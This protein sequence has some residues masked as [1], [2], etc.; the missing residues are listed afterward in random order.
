MSNSEGGL[1]GDL[2]VITPHRA[3]LE[4]SLI[5]DFD[6][7]FTWDEMREMQGQ[8]LKKR[9]GGFLSATEAAV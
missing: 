8:V 6:D 3:A 4:S 2:I 5:L 7:G 9:K 1:Y